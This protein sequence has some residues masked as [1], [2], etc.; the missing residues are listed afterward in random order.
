[1]PT[2]PPAP[3]LQV[4]EAAPQDVDA[5]VQ[6]MHDFYA[7]SSYPLDRGWAAASFRALLDRP[8]LGRVWIA[9]CDNAPVGHAVLTVRHTMEFG[10]LSAY[11]DDL[12]VM[13]AFRRRGAGHALLL[14]LLAECRIRDCRSLQVEVGAANA[15]ALALYS[16]FGLERAHGERL[17]L[18]RAL[19]ASD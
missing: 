6:L 9:R 1:M 8:A 15:P 18:S 4:H 5:L 7:E 3:K 12:F 10:G 19:P 14:A 13:P 2:T 17:L 16:S 11:I